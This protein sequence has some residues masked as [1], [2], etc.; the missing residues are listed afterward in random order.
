[1]VDI[2]EFEKNFQNEEVKELNDEELEEH[3]EKI[4]KDVE[5]YKI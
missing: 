3:I 1:M 5:N 4:L 2:E